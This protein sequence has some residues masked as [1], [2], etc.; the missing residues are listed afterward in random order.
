M[1]DDPI[2]AHDG[3]INLPAPDEATLIR[4]AEDVL[5]GATESLFD[6]GTKLFKGGEGFFL[7]GPEESCGEILSTAG[8]ELQDALMSEAR[9]VRYAKAEAE[10][11][12]YLEPETNP[13]IKL[14]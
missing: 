9:K 5:G 6:D 11:Q 14:D 4:A 13:F 12:K 2:F 10:R 1:S 3:T 7:Q 8:R